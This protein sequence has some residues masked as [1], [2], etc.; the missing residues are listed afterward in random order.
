MDIAIGVVMIGVIVLIGVWV[1][2]SSRADAGLDRLAGRIDEAA[3]QAE[4]IGERRAAEL[5][6][7]ARAAAEEVGKQFARRRD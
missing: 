1:V 4:E 3:T 6:D 5:R 2:R 7:A